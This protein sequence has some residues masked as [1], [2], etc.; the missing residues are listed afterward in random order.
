MKRF[1]LNKK[2]LQLIVLLLLSFV[3]GA[4]FIL[5]KRGLESYSEI[6]VGSIRIFSASLFMLPFLFK[7]L[8]RLK[9]KHMFPLFIT[10]FLGN[11]LPAMLF[12]KAQTQ[13]SS[14]V[15]GMLNTTFPVIA[16]IIGYLFYNDR[17]GT[18]KT[19]GIIIGLIGAVGLILSADGDLKSS[20]NYYALFII[21]A[22]VMYGISINT[23]KHRL[24]DL[25]GFTISVFT[26]ATIAPFAGL[27][28]L[29]TDFSEA[30]LSPERFENMGYIVFLGVFGSAITVSLYYMLTEHTSV[31]FSSLSTYI[32]PIFALL[33]GLSDG[34]RVTW[35][36]ILFI[37]IVLTG[38]YLVNKK[39]KKDRFEEIPG[40]EK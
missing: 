17:P 6:Q 32:I 30:A 19:L 36:H 11:L 39:S 25:D 3:W 7:R 27:T 22:V 35:L 23:M 1:D 31:A 10:G 4:S 38:V 8:K 21:L 24:K 28:L 12:A 18:G 9:R 13:V 14:S 5:I 29:F 37:A 34:E 2:P 33:W 26:F 20:V 40:N 16:L 15:A